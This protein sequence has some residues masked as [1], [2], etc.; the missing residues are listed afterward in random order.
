MLD[1]AILP[2]SLADWALCLDRGQCWLFRLELG[3]LSFVGVSSRLLRL[4]AVKMV[5]FPPS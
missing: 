1:L 5:F 3:T 4:V 2:G